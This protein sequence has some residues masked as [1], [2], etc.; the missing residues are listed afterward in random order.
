M[1]GE[2]AAAMAFAES[3]QHQFPALV[4]DETRDFT[5][6]SQAVNL[7]R[8]VQCA[9]PVFIAQ[10]GKS[11][12]DIEIA[13]KPPMPKG[14]AANFDQRLERWRCSKTRGRM[15]EDPDIGRAAVGFDQRV[16]VIK[17]VA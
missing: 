8:R 14:A 15:S 7:A 3:M 6:P 17:P 11:A 2:A 5:I 10:V 4:R 13:V 1:P 12:L 16:A 9:K